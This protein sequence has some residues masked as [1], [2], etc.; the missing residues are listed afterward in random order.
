MGDTVPP[1]AESDEENVDPGCLIAFGG[2]QHC[3]WNTRA[4]EVAG[5]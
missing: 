2:A 1:L 4:P 3:P 5:A